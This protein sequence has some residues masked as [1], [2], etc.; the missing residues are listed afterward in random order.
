MILGTPNDRLQPSDYPVEVLKEWAQETLGIKRCA[1]GH[2]KA[3]A[4]ILSR[5]LHADLHGARIEFATIARYA[6]R[7][8]LRT[9]LNQLCSAGLLRRSPD[10]KRA[11]YFYWGRADQD[12]DQDQSQA[13]NERGA[14][15]YVSIQREAEDVAFQRYVKRVGMSPDECPY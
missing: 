11:T 12:K 3:L 15:L 7:Q 10:L 5:M 8:T 13:R 4:I 2:L 1:P 9:L 6:G 14:A